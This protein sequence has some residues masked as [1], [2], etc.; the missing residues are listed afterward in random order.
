MTRNQVRW[1]QFGA[2][3]GIVAVFWLVVANVHDWLKFP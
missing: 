3:C 2:A 1:V